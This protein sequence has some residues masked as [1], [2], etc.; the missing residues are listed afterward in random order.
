LNSVG[1]ISGRKRGFRTSAIRRPHSTPIAVFSSSARG[2]TLTHRRS[3]GLRFVICPLRMAAV[4]AGYGMV[5]D[6][7]ADERPIAFDAMLTEAVSNNNWTGHGD[8]AM[9]PQDDTAGTDPAEPSRAPPAPSHRETAQDDPIPPVF[10]DDLLRMMIAALPSIEHLTDE[11]RSDRVAA[12]MLALRVRPTGTDR[13]DA[14]H[15][16]GACP[17]RRADVLPPR[18]AGQPAGG[19]RLTPVRQCRD[20]VAHPGRR[21][22]QP[23][24]TTGTVREPVGPPRAVTAGEKSRGRLRNGAPGGDPS[25]EPRCGA[26]TRTGAACRSPAMSNGRCR[27]HGGKSTGPRTRD[28]VERIRAARTTHGFWS[29]EGRAFRRFCQELLIGTR[30]LMQVAAQQRAPRRKDPMQSGATTEG[31][32]TDEHG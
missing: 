11:Q 16:R 26:R 5:T 20:P 27:M 17:P 9:S 29:P 24:G 3:T 32:T 4:A 13:G 10:T 15:P 25:T 22:A 19:D 18:R 6:S 21:A 30:R 23:G 31:G 2:L 28:G 1:R 12:A 14:R 7:A 8:D